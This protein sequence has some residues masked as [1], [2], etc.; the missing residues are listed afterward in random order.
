[1]GSMGS[2]SPG[3]HAEH[4]PH[5]IRC[6]LKNRRMSDSGGGVES[7]PKYGIAKKQF[8]VPESELLTFQNTVN[9]IVHAAIKNDLE[10]V[11]KVVA[12][13]ET[14]GG[15][16][17]VLINTNCEILG[18]AALHGAVDHGHFSV[19]EWLIEN[20]AEQS[21]CIENGYYP[22]HYAARSGRKRITSFLLDHGG[23]KRCQSVFEGLFPIEVARDYGKINVEYLFKDP[24]GAISNLKSSSVEA[25][26]FH[27]YWDSPANDGGEPIEKYKVWVQKLDRVVVERKKEFSE[28]DSSNS[29]EDIFNQESNYEYTRRGDPMKFE[30]TDS[31]FCIDNVS[32]A[33]WYDI[34]VFSANKV[35]WAEPK[36]YISLRLRTASS[37]P[38]LLMAPFAMKTTSHTITVGW[39]PPGRENGE[40]ILKYELQSRRSGGGVWSVVVCKSVASLKNNF[41]TVT[42]LNPGTSLKFRIRVSNVIGWS[43]WSPDSLAVQSNAAADIVHRDARFIKLEWSKPYFN[44]VRFRGKFEVQRRRILNKRD[45]MRLTFL[46]KNNREEELEKWNPE[47]KGEWIFC[48]FTKTDEAKYTVSGLLPATTFEFRI[49]C[50]LEPDPM[51]WGHGIECDPIRTDMDTPEPPEN[52]T[53]GDISE[54]SVELAW[55]KAYD[56]GL[57]VEQYEVMLTKDPEYDHHGEHWFAATTI[58]HTSAQVTGLDLGTHYIFKVRAYNEVGWSEFSTPLKLRTRAIPAP[59]CP[60]VKLE[61]AG[62]TFVRIGWSLKYHE[63]NY[64][65]VQW[66]AQFARCERIGESHGPWKDATP[67]GGKVEGSVSSVLVVPIKPVSKYVFR[68]RAKGSEDGGWS[69]WSEKS[70]VYHSGRRF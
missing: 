10:S 69:T 68:L 45:K 41:F 13:F 9:Q 61:E 59:P 8:G 35:G 40:R 21:P 50:V 49:R 32:A 57:F 19:V 66:H 16:P 25:F 60:L 17:C 62:D 38:D 67:G 63:C 52:L 12:N 47:E 53:Q 46:L 7:R 2:R 26:K 55:D 37:V 31:S 22:V 15:S 44:R 27:L 36:D 56:N 11:Q 4:F 6:R 14:R 24:P 51:D 18:R 42:K 30:A 3:K 54:Y 58:E 43:E 64:E 39:K 29:D 20:G 5:I 65:I 33:T 28:E 23:E 48:G 34:T 1:M 70:K